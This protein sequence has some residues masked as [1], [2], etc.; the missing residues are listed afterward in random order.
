MT[1]STHAHYTYAIQLRVTM[2]YWHRSQISWIAG[3]A[4][5]TRVIVAG[6]TNGCAAFA[7][8]TY[9]TAWSE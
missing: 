3:M 4:Q 6:N 1:I 8:Y 9:L 7:K 5:I 2:R